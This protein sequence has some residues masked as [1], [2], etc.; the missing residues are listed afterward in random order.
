MTDHLNPPL[1]GEMGFDDFRDAVMNLVGRDDLDA[2]RRLCEEQIVMPALFVEKAI[3]EI[4]P[5]N[6]M[7]DVLFL[8]AR[9]LIGASPDL[10]HWLPELERKR[11]HVSNPEG[12]SELVGL[13]VDSGI[14]LP[15]QLVR[16]V[17]TDISGMD[18]EDPSTV[19]RTFADMVVVGA[20]FCARYLKEVDLDQYSDR[21]VFRLPIGD[22]PEIAEFEGR[23]LRGK[24][25]I[26]PLVHPEFEFILAKYIGGK[27]RRATHEERDLFYM[28]VDFEINDESFFVIEG[29]DGRLAVYLQSPDR[30][31][32]IDYLD[33]WRLG[34]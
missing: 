23:V 8:T 16:L 30:I 2:L 10:R 11:V 17:R 18:L 1:E 32:F 9:K 13:I 33:I 3:E 29:E 21:A 12:G 4:A 19:D 20:G 31:R 15:E 25:R 5:G 26:L 34:T 14:R 28:F 27:V 7:N 22:P 6:S 24:Q